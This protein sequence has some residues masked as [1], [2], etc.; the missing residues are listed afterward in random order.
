MN[1]RGLLKYL[2]NDFF[3]ENLKS[4]SKDDVLSEL[5]EPLVQHA[6]VTNRDILLETLRKR[7][8]LGSTGIGKNVAIPHCRTLTVSEIHIVIGMSKNGIHYDAIDKKKVHLFFLIVAPP[9]EETSLYLP[10]LGKIVE[11][12]RDSKLRRQLLKVHD[13]ETFLKIFEL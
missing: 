6:C 5:I 8:T 1:S 4:K 2:Q 7:E 10:I 12:V 9:Q 3:I 13:F 11:I